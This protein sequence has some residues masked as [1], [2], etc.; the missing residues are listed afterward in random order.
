VI[1]IVLLIAFIISCSNQN[2]NK[3]EYYKKGLSFIEGGNAGGAVI[4]F[5]KAIEKDQSYFEARYQLA[6]AYILQSKY[7]SAKKELRKVLLLNPS[8]KKAHISMAKVHL[9][10]DNTDDAIEQINLFLKGNRGDS[11]AYELAAIAYAK[12]KE[13]TTAEETLYKALKIYPESEPL[14]LVLADVYMAT[15]R[16]SEAEII[17]NKI[18]DSDRKNKKALYLLVKL[19]HKQNDVGGLLNIYQKILDVDPEDV[20][21]KFELGYTHL[22][23]N[24]LEKAREIAGE[25]MRSHEK[26]PEG[27][28]LMGLVHFNEKDI[29]M[30]IDSLQQ[31][32]RD[33]PVPGAHYFLGLSYFSKGSFE[34]SI[35]EFLKVLDMKPDMIQPRLMIAVVHL[36]KGRAEVAMKETLRVLKAD[37]SNAFAHN[38]LGSIYLAL[39]NGDSAM[40]EF[41]KAIELNPEFV[42]AYLKKGTFTLLTG[43][44][45]KAEKEFINAVEIA[46]ELLNSRIVLSKFYLKNK[47]FDKAVNTLKE[48]LNGT[49]GDAVLFNIMAAAYTGSENKDKA[50]LYFKKAIAS[51]PKFFLSYFNL[52]RLHI[53]NGE[54]EKA[55]EACKKVLEMDSYNVMALLMMAGIMEKDKKYNEALSYY[56]K[57]KNQ[58]KPEAY[59]SLA[60]YY[61]RK[62]DHESAIKVLDEAVAFKE[63][64]INAL[65]MKGRIYISEKKY[66]KALLVYR[67]VKRISP[68]LGLKRI[69]GVYAVAGEY[70]RAIR[71]LETVQAGRV[72]KAGILGQIV[73]LNIMKRDYTEAE[74]IANEVILLKPESDMGYRI[75][76]SVY[77]ADSQHQKAVDNLKKAER[78]NPENLEIKVVLG[79]TYLLMNKTQK[80]LGVFKGIEKGNPDYVPVYFFQA[81]ILEKMGKK[82]SAVEKHKE[83]LALSPDYTPSLNNLAYLY[84]EGY[85][86]VGRAVEMAKAARRLQPHDGRIADTLGWVYFKTGN[87][88]DAIKNFVEALSYLPDEPSIRY[89]LGLVYREKGMHAEAEVQLEKAIELGRRSAFPEFADA[90]KTLEG[91]KDK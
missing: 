15:E 20:L 83:V 34:K 27:K 42:D 75:L 14:K 46:P 78:L 10:T 68:K 60:G 25:L 54:K 58:K 86:P 30:A 69:V 45:E 21:A 33:A 74:R 73:N 84:V 38:L 28:Y 43:D 64:D 52:A 32:V 71:A 39:G 59:L 37:S 3:K 35:S 66:K 72:E 23:N 80:A 1:Y 65:D 9:N 76:A 53:K 13:Y 41:D 8:F 44:A 4:A 2:L 31:T 18:I 55:T 88:E 50:T 63:D 22:R 12:K 48:G 26:R 47:Q 40:D 89:H 56:L 61:L 70:D 67:N 82:K 11:R 79:R 19:R 85:G 24:N 51:N 77:N 5:K 87:H 62:D 16:I 7:E 81:G 49:P 90:K 6:L 91:L 29:D 17:I 36:R 57:A